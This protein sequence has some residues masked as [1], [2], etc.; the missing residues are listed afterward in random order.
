MRSPCRHGSPRWKPGTIG[1]FSIFFFAPVPY[2]DVSDL[3]SISN[4]WQ[5]ILA[6]RWSPFRDGIA[7]LAVFAA[8]LTENESLRFLACAVATTGTITKLAFNANPFI[9]FDGYYI[10][11]DLTQPIE[12]MVRWTE[13]GARSN[14]TH[15]KAI[16]LFA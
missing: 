2:I 16:L 1:R 14:K 12:S 7:T 11:A 13:R 4:R 3:W 10:L 6:R 9:R 5:R 8:F 15:F